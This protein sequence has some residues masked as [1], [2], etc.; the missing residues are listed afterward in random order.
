VIV[1]NEDARAWLWDLMGFCGIARSSFTG[2]STTFFNEGQRN[3]GLK[4]QAELVKYFPEKLHHDDE[5]RREA[6][7][8]T[9]SRSPI[10][11]RA[12]R[13]TAGPRIR[14]C[15]RQAYS[16]TRLR[17]AGGG[18]ARGPCCCGSPPQPLRPSCR[19]GTKR[20]QRLRSCGSACA[21]SQEGRIIAAPAEPRP[22]A[23]DMRKYLVEK[24]G[25][26]DEVKKLAEADLQ[27]QFDAAKAKEQARGQ[28]GRGEGRGH[29]DRRS[30][31]GSRSTRR[32]SPTSRG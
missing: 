25:K 2:N 14:G 13:S 18:G 20:S 29:Q 4:V 15:M 27:K 12:P 22:T 21:G 24:G 11:R 6:C 17:R 23:D 7:G 3:V 9:E 5:G 10:S 16:W 1:E 28:G 30:R 31:K 19:T 32:C 26:D 8:I